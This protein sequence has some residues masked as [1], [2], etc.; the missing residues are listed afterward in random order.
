MYASFGRDI[1][2][3]QKSTPDFIHAARMHRLIDSLNRGG[4]TGELQKS[5][6]WPM[7]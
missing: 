4:A 1:Q 2:T 5:D 3:G 7:T 6:A